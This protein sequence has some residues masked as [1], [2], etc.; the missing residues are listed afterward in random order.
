M[1]KRLQEICDSL[2]AVCTIRRCAFSTCDRTAE[3]FDFGHG[4]AGQ[5]LEASFGFPKFNPC[6]HK[7]SF[8]K[9]SAQALECRLSYEG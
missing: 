7:V 4:H 8:S 6:R 5:D 3:E 2:L 1:A 9:A